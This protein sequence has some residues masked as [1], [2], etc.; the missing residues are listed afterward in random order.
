ML[1]HDIEEHHMSYEEY[2]E[3]Y[4]CYQQILIPMTKD[5]FNLLKEALL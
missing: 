4:D 2:L 5:E 3:Q 1:I